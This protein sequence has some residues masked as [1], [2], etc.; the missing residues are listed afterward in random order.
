VGR[1]LS[2]WSRP[3][4]KQPATARLGWRPW[5]TAAVNMVG[6]V[7][8]LAGSVLKLYGLDLRLL[9]NLPGGLCALLLPRWLMVRGFRRTTLATALCAHVYSEGER[10]QGSGAAGCLFMALTVR[11]SVAPP[12]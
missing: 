9:H 12:P 11:F 8:L 10:F 3:A 2:Q 4:G 1:S 5:R 6:Y 7:S